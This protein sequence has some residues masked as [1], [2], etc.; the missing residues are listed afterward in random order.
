MSGSD[1]STAQQLDRR[2]IEGWAALERGDLQ[3]ARDALRD[4]HS[5]NPSHPALPLLA[6][7]IRRARPKPVPWGALT[8]LLLLSAAAGFGVYSWTARR[9]GPSTATNESPETSSRTQEPIAPSDAPA[10][11]ENARGTA[12]AASP[13]K[14]PPRGPVPE[15]ASDDAQIRQAV[16]RFAKTYS[17]KWGTLGFGQ[18]DVAPVGDT[19]TVSCRAART[20]SSANSPLDGVWKFSCRKSGGSWKIVSLQPPGQ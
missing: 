16:A 8:L 7:G 14:A 13:P 12:G 11:A 18:C 3:E 10:P 20:S 6:A 5:G 9:S 17:S 1:S 15:D 2:I 19:A 4:V